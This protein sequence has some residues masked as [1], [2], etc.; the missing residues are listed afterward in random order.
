MISAFITAYY[1][2]YQTLVYI[3][4]LQIRRKGRGG[5]ETEENVEGEWNLERTLKGGDKL[6]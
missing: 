5:D 1:E 4:A 6:H 2:T 3:V